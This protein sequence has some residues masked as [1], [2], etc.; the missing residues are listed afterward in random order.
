MGPVSDEEARLLQQLVEAERAHP[1]E[2]DRRAFW[3]YVN[4]FM[5]DPGPHIQHAG[6]AG[7]SIPV[8][9]EAF[10]GLARR[11]WLDVAAEPVR[12]RWQ[13]HQRGNAIVLELRQDPMRE[14][15]FDITDAGRDYYTKHIAPKPQ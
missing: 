7:G 6:L 15:W 11:G 3:Y 5:N 10:S 2:T 13:Q 4:A 9:A 14:W 12:L 1:N 8:E